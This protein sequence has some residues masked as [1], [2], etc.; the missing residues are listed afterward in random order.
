MVHDLALLP[1]PFDHYRLSGACHLI[2]GLSLITARPRGCLRDAG[3]GQGDTEGLLL[4]PR[5]EDKAP[6]KSDPF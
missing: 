2:L 5:I 6:T 4:S 3:K 1:N